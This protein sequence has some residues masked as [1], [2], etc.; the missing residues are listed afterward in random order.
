MLRFTLYRLYAGVN[1]RKRYV[2]QKYRFPITDSPL[3][4]CRPF[5][6]SFFKLF[7]SLFHEQ[8]GIQKQYSI[9][10]RGCAFPLFRLCPSCFIGIPL[11]RSCFL[12][13]YVILFRSPLTIIPACSSSISTS[14][15]STTSVLS[16]L[17]PSSGF[18]FFVRVYDACVPQ[19][20]VLRSI[21]QTNREP[22]G[23][24]F[25]PLEPRSPFSL[26]ACR[27]PRSSSR[28]NAHRAS[29]LSFSFSSGTIR[30]CCLHR[31]CPVAVFVVHT[32]VNKPLIGLTP[33]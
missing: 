22:T 1:A 17:L 24:P 32:S 23:W 29:C 8:Q 7:L 5:L 20:H 6:L 10:G 19:D 16:L 26:F 12:S 14:V 3:S 15:V 27:F 28:Y 9:H 18:F 31:T 4:L 33:I 2:L 25:N 21:V 30:R 13:R 11:F